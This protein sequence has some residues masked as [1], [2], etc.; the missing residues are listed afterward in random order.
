MRTVLFFVNSFGKGGAERVCVN[1][2]LQYLKEGYKVCFV[3]LLRNVDYLDDKYKFEIL[4]LGIDEKQPK[5]EAISKILRQRKKVNNFILK[6]MPEEG[7]SLVTAHLPLSHL[8]ASMS[9]LGKKCLYV[10]HTSLLQEKRNRWVYSFLYKRKM[11]ICVSKG[12]QIEMNNDMKIAEKRTKTIYN[13]VD[14][15][16]IQ[17]LSCENVGQIKR[18]YM[19]VVGRLIE[20]K[21]FD[22]AIQIFFEGDFYKKYDLYILGE[23]ALKSDL[24]DLVKKYGIS[25]YVKF[26]GWQANVYKWMKNAQL[27]LQTSDREAF[28]MVLIEALASGTKIVASDCNFGANEILLGDYAQYIANREDIN[29]YIQL[30]KKAIEEFEITFKHDILQVCRVENVC[31]EYLK[32]YGEING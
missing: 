31:N 5:S 26:M 12:L 10:Q 17:E 32:L 30:I 22:K 13:P 28:P 19:L 23:G 2:G 24:I 15:D 6:N 21:R 4:N 16:K 3:T 14:V 29:G 20:T 11:N 18:P 7:Y 27:I 1:L 8:C 25:K 9:L